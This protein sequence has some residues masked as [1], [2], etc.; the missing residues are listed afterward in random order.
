MKKLIS[1]TSVR[2][3]LGF[4]FIVAL[5]VFRNTPAVKAEDATTV[6][7]VWEVTSVSP[8]GYETEYDLNHKLSIVRQGDNYEVKWLDGP[9]AGSSVIYPGSRMRIAKTFN[10]LISDD[11]FFP[12]KPGRGSMAETQMQE[13]AGITWPN[14]V[15]YTLSADGNSLQRSECTVKVYWDNNGHYSRNEVSPGFY[16]ETLNRVYGPVKVENR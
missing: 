7:G 14:T 3:V 6:E 1:H 5:F 11:V 8:L 13:I 2:L 16:K 9:R 15:S 12:G 10:V 4:L